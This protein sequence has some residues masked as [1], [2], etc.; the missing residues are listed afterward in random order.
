MITV[1]WERGYVKRRWLLLYP[2]GT[3]GEGRDLEEPANSRIPSRFRKMPFR[4]AYP[5]AIIDDM[6]NFDR[7]V[8]I[9]LL[10]LVDGGC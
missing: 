3:G 10:R 7:I 5:V 4:F 2:L 6:R 1:T 8:E 9:E